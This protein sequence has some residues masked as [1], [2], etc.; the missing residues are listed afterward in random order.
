[1]EN[2]LTERTRHNISVESRSSEEKKIVD[3]MRQGA[4]WGLL[5][6]MLNVDNMS[7]LVESNMK[8]Y[9]NSSKLYGKN[10]TEQ[11]RTSSVRDLFSIIIILFL[12][13]KNY[14]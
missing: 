9:A 2:L 12:F 6:Y 13:A 8:V 4:I 5:I 7:N 1:M 10:F 3:G 14:L 11:L